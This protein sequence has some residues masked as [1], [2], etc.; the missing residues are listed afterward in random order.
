MAH[1]VRMLG[2]D[3]G[4]RNYGVAAVEL[5]KR[6]GRVTVLR[7]AKLVHPLDSFTDSY[8]KKSRAYLREVRTWVQTYKVNAFIAE[9][10]QTRGTKT[11]SVE[12]VSVM[13][14]MMTVQFGALPH[15]YITASTWKNDVN[16]KLKAE[17][18]DLKQLYK[19]V[20]VEAHQLDAVLMAIYG[21]EKATG[22][23]VKYEWDRLLTQV[24]QTGDWK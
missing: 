21:L 5:N 3:P 18:T 9:R 13:L 15:K 23:E 12:L 2:M 4:Y 16:R 19:E 20:E 10:F 14:G 8:V 17:N 11:I 1:R 22:I 24:N 7:N 6:S